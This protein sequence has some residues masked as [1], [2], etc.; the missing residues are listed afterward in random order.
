[1][2][3]PLGASPLRWISGGATDRGRV[4]ATNQDAFLDRPDLGLWTVADGMGGHSD[5]ALASRTIVEGLSVLP[6]PRWLGASVR[7]IRGVL[8]G[9]NQEADQSGGGP[10]RW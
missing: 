2:S 8:Q 3:A 1:M 9:V 4:R 5:G 7:A 10:R 6:H